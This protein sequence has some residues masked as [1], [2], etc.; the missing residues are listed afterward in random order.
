MSEFIDPNSTMNLR[1][2]SNFDYEECARLSKKSDLI[3]LINYELSEIDEEQ[4]RPG[5]T[6]W[7]LIG[8]LVTLSWL[9][10]N[11]LPLSKVNFINI[12]F[13]YVSLS[14]I[15]EFIINL[16]PIIS[17][18]GTS[19]SREP[20]YFFT[21]NLFGSYRIYIFVS[22]AQY[23]VLLLVAL[24][25]GGQLSVITKISI[26]ILMGYSILV[27]I[28][29]IILS[30][31]KV[32]I[33]PQ[34]M[35]WLTYLTASI[36]SMLFIISLFGC[37]KKLVIEFEA[38]TPEEFRASVILLLIAY[39][40]ILMSKVRSISP[41]RS[42]LISLRRDIILDKIDLDQAQKQIDLALSG[43]LVEDV[44]QERIKE[45]LDCFDQI[46]KE[47]N[48]L[49]NIMKS[50]KLLLPISVEEQDHSQS[51]R[52]LMDISK[53]KKNNLTNLFNS[54]KTSIKKF[55]EKKNQIIRLDDRAYEKIQQVEGKINIAF[56]NLERLYKN[57]EKENQEIEQ[58]LV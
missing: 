36:I 28:F 14:L 49:I 53:T 41:V 48:E 6:F 37:F 17:G 50:I 43:L 47:F 24:K 45:V 58:M 34:R 27:W 18:Q 4:K 57:Y 26:I 35:G 12:G 42:Y 5:W 13:I 30:F 55:E 56:S 32:P 29:L 7:A 51:I 16:I 25:I 44:L 8:A 52:T 9:F 31:L 21:M 3:D 20:R 54:L 11:Q 15:I 40:I 2:K 1:A 22:L 19:H 23:T 33:N 38:F 39:T 10:I 46:N